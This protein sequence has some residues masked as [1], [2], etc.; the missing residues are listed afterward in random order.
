MAVMPTDRHA[1][2]GEAD[3]QPFV[4][5]SLSQRL[6]RHGVTVQVEIYA[7]GEGKWILEVVDQEEA[8]HVWD[9]HFVTDSEALAAAIQAL[10]D[11][12]LEFAAKPVSSH[13]VH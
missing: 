7:D 11:E 1:F 3:G 5:S 4:N 12:P 6:T 10:E 2:Y 8:S 9:E 13:D